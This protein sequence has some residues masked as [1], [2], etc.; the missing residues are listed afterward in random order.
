MVKSQSQYKVPRTR[1]LMTEGR[2]WMYQMSQ[3][4]Q[5][6]QIHPFSTFLVYSGPQLIGQC[7][8]SL[9][10]GDL[11][12]ILNLLIQMLTSS[13]KHFKDTLRNVYRLSGHL[14]GTVKL[15]HKIIFYR[16]LGVCI[17][18][19]TYSYQGTYRGTSEYNCLLV[20]EV[21]RDATGPDTLAFGIGL[22]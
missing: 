11:L 8:P 17:E 10:E 18:Q 19:E 6:E 1:G 5:R 9:S 7:P 12:Y 16:S 13:K 20:T 21:H 3:L 4:R 2:K 15:I 22:A 14:L